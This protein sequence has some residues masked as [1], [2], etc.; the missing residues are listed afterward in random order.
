[1]IYL[2]AL[3]SVY[4]R[5][6]A[7]HFRAALRTRTNERLHEIT[8]VSTAVRLLRLAPARPWIHIVQM[9]LSLVPSP[10]PQLSSLAV[11][12][13]FPNYVFYV[14]N[15]CILGTRPVLTCVVS[16][17]W[18]G[19]AIQVE[20]VCPWLLTG[21]TAIPVI[22]IA[23]VPTVLEKSVFYEYLNVASGYR[24]SLYTVV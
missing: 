6:Q 22:L 7:G 19:L 10:P 14:P 23:V 17:S 3:I 21:G 15:L 4:G 18:Y 11:P 1:M 20:F 12:T 5:K 24:H 16:L 8:I 9:N 2:N 13:Y